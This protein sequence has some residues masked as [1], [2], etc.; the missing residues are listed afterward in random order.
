MNSIQQT[1]ENTLRARILKRAKR[2]GESGV[3]VGGSLTRTLRKCGKA[4][5][6]C[7]SDPDGRHEAYLLTWKEQGKTRA[8]YVPVDMIKEVS[9]WVKERQK[10]KEL[11]AEMDSLAVAML[12]AHAASSR[13]KKDGTPRRK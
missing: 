4:G 9:S 7:A 6:R 10:I 1:S 5:C 8:A 3:S 11:L 13:A 2:L 12:K